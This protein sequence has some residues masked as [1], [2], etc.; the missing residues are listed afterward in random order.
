MN[1]SRAERLNELHVLVLDSIHAEVGELT[2]NRGGK[3]RRVD[4]PAALRDRSDDRI[5]ANHATHLRRRMA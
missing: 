1:P 2:E 4:P 3:S 5:Q